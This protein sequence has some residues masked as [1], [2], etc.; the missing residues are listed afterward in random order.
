ME[1]HFLLATGTES[2]RRG[3]GQAGQ[4]PCV[5]VCPETMY[6][7]GIPCVITLAYSA[8]LG[9]YS[10]TRSSFIHPFLPPPPRPFVRSQAN[11]SEYTILSDQS[12]NEPPP[13]PHHRCIGGGSGE[14]DPYRT[15]FNRQLSSV[16][17]PPTPAACRPA[18]RCAV[19]TKA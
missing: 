11:V 13:P 4:E 18:D 17:P 2:R 7:V 19:V 10:V 16:L 1:F 8:A 6:G 3:S 14:R 12:I 9:Q 15:R 5:P